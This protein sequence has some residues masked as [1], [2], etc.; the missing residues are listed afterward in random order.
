MMRRL[1]IAKVFVTHV[2][3]IVILKGFKKSKITK[4][5]AGGIYF[6][7]PAVPV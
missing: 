5:R 4:K 6:Q 3:Y 1:S 2:A 7:L